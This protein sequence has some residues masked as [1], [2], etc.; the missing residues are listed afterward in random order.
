MV[1]F[2]RM[3]KLEPEQ[4]FNPRKEYDPEMYIPRPTQESRFKN[5]LKSDLGILV[6]GQSG[7]GKTWLTRRVLIEEKYF[8]KPINLAS[9]TIN[10]SISMCFKNTMARDNW[11]I[12]TKYT[13]SKKA[14]VK[15][16]IAEGGVDHSAEYIDNTDYFMEFLKYMKFRA[17]E[18]HR[19]RY[20]VFENFEV[21]ANNETLL[22]ELTNY[23]ILMDDDEVLKFNT[24]IIIVAASSDIQTYFKKVANI[25]TIDNRLIELP[26][27]KTLTTHQ[28]FELIEKGFNKLDVKFLNDEELQYFKENINWVTGGIPQRLHEFCLEL[29]RKFKEN[30]WQASIELFGEAVK[31]WLSTSLNKNYAAVSKIFDYTPNKSTRKNQVL[32][33]LGLKDKEQFNGK[34]IEED[35]FIEFPLTTEGKKISVIPILNSLCETDP[36]ILIKDEDTK[37]YRFA[38]NK[39]ALCLRTMLN[40][41]EEE[42][43]EIFD[44]EEV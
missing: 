2:F 3:S 6:Q 20:I 29:S 18:K 5:A 38:D 9:V 34:E 41:T 11:Q 14:T 43:V 25:S 26:E 4:V 35:M 31:E 30:N 19:K 42:I 8:F 7:T 13:E 36:V 40:K 33:C 23:I 28:S 24:K 44:L 12:R 16:P 17:K 15:V 21:I 37:K 1:R 39:F 10:Q 27:I 22:K 32:Y